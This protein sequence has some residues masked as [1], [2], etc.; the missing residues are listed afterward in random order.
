MDLELLALGYL[1]ACTAWDDGW[2][3]DLGPELACLLALRIALVVGASGF[4]LAAYSLYG[5]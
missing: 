2:M 1:L 5:V 3:D 4:G